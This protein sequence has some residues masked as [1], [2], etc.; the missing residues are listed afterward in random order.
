MVMGPHVL[1]EKAARTKSSTPNRWIV[2]W[3]VRNLGQEPL[4][5]V[6]GRLPHSQFRA[7]ERQ[8][9]P[10]LVVLAGES[11]RLEFEVSCN[12]LPGAVVENAFLILSVRW[13][14][15]PWRVLAR[16]RVVLD[17]ES[18]PQTTTE[19]VTTQRI[20]FSTEKAET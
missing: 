1:V 20:G 15:E 12:G 14:G 6:A 11:T 9:R 17:D 13:S 5:I 3:N 10:S 19:L 16:M 4:E 2:V 8:L 7:E 18:G